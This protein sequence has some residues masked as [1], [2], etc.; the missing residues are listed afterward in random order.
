M[1]ESFGNGII[2]IF[3]IAIVLHIL[4]LFFKFKIFQKARRQGWI[5]FIPIY[6]NW[7]LFELVE[8][9]GWLCLIPGVSNVMIMIANYMLAIKFGKSIGF[10]L[11]TAILPFIY[12]SIIAYDHS[13][14]EGNNNSKASNVSDY[15]SGYR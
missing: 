5:A 10:A 3:I 7:V 9:P 14:Y 13:A 8:I 2:F 6:N 12:L 1:Y 15:L 4:T 11:R